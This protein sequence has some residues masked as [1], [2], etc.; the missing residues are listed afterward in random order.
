LFVL[1][2][3]VVAVSIFGDD[4]PVHFEVAACQHT[5]ALLYFCNCQVKVNPSLT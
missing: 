5:F 2:V 1:V 4:A 3:A